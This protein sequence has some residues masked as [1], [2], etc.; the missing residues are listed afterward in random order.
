MPTAPRITLV[1]LLL[2]TNWSVTAQQ[3]TISGTVRDNFNEPL[4]GAN[5]LVEGTQRG[6]ITGPDGTYQIQAAEGERVLFSYVGYITA[7][8]MVDTRNNY[9][10][11]LMPG[12]D[13]EE[14]V[15]VGYGTTSRKTLTD[16]I[17]SISREQIKE[18]PV[19][20]VQGAL[21]GKAAGVQI[22]QVSGRA[23]GGFK[24]RV[25]GVATINGNQEPLYVI[26]G[27]PIFKSDFSVNGSPINDLISLNPAD[28]ESIEILKDASA[29]AIYGSRG[30][31]GVVLI[32][33]KSGKKGKT[34]FSFNSSY[35]W[36]EPS[37]TLEW[38]NTEEYVELYTEAALNSGFTEDDAAF[39][40]NLFAEDEAD[41]REGAVDTDWQSLGLVSGAVQDISF[42]ASG[43]EEKTTFFLSTGYNKTEAII[44]GN[45]LERYTI[46]A[47][48]EHK[49][50]DW[51]TLGL[52]S[53]LSKSQL[54]RIANDNQFAN[55]LQ[56]IAQIP[57]SSPYLSDGVTP[58]TETTLYYNFLMDAFNGEHETNIWRA[59]AKVYGQINFT[60][61]LYLRSEFGYDLTDQMEERFFGSLTQ[62]ASTNGFADAYDDK[63]E[64]FVINNYLQY[65]LNREKLQLEATLGM[66]FEELFNKG[67]YIEGQDFPSDQLRKLASAGEITGGTTYESRATLVSYFARASA[68]LF[69]TW[70]LKASLRVDGSSRFGVNSQYGTFPAASVGWLASNEP[71][72]QNNNTISNLKLRASWGVTGN[73]N[74]N[75][76]ASRT[77]FNTNT[78]NLRPGF[79]L[80]RLGDPNLGWEE[81]EQYNFGLD[82]GLFNDRINA[83][84]DYYQKNTEDLLFSVPIPS[85]NGIRSVD[86]NLGEIQNRG[87]E[88]VLDTKNILGENFS[89]STNI[90]LAFNTNEVK[91]LPEGQDIIRSNKIIRE[92]ETVASWYMVEYAGVDPA[93][94]DALF[95]LN[96]ELADGSL[97]RNTTNDFN[98][99]S[100]RI[101]GN[102]FP[103][104]IGGMTHN[105]RFKGIDFSFTFQ[106]EWG[107]QIYNGGGIYQSSNADFFDN[108]TRDQLNRWQQPGDITNVPQARLFGGNGSQTSSR[109]LEDGDF[110]RL[111]NLTLGYT[112]PPDI[113]RRLGMDRLRVYF[114][115]VNLLTITDYS[116]WDPES[117]AD[118]AQRNSAASGLAFYSPPQARTLTIGFNV[119]F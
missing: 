104:V 107:A 12:N 77:E 3:K 35:G 59:F 83:S 29:A 105:F 89:W 38:L 63:E 112:L 50:N 110:I 96:T 88:F 43:G 113:T 28:I 94:G 74:T 37:N 118:F 80:Q 17:A 1:L 5:V 13:L 27:V 98:E 14:V 69:D 9:N 8:V 18:V 114:T 64:K 22:T 101:L 71:F 55:P 15:V 99:A 100:R 53:N 70:L 33:T 75:P 36:S 20:S 57:F 34:R 39:F 31:N 2:L 76:F 61:N 86:R 44:R 119:D 87:L 56:A 10:I 24:I 7:I 21:V 116:G 117:T 6:T 102:P 115:G 25:R 103:D 52:N 16:N 11:T 47:N 66:S 46:R 45:T 30:T 97:D 42:S 85:T 109:Y 41:W 67:I 79:F 72:L 91:S 82:T 65:R 40:F 106:G 4:L 73:S 93:N 23:E 108:Q 92:G 78:Y 60:D 62:S 90:N 111:R 51:L 48:I 81:T 32:T 95:F 84:V 68:T 54:A 49:A 19:P 26:D 58:N